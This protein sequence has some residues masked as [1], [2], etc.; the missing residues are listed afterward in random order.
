M[1]PTVNGAAARARTDGKANIADAAAVPD[2]N[3]RRVMGNERD[4]E[5]PCGLDFARHRFCDALLSIACNSNAKDKLLKNLH[6]LKRVR[7]RR[8][9][10]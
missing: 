10:S 8:G 9:Q 5:A 2:R 6:F 7:V 1:K 3:L 4:M